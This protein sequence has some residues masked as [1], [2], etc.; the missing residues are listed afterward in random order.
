MKKKYRD[1]HTVAVGLLC[2]AVLWLTGAGR[3]EDFPK[4][5]ISNGLIRAELYLPDT[6]RGYYRATRFDWSGVIPSLRYHGH[7]YAGQWFTKYDPHIHDAIMGPVEAFAPLGYGDSSASDGRFTVIGVGLLK[8]DGSRAYSA[9]HY[10][11]IDNAG[12]WHIERKRSQVVFTQDLEQGAYPYRYSKT[13]TLVRGRPEMT[14]SHHLVN[15]GIRPIRTEVYDHNLWMLDHQPTG[16][17]CIV[18]FSFPVHAVTE[19]ARGVGSLVAVDGDSLAVLKELSG[20]EQ[21]YAV[22]NYGPDSSYDIRIENTLSGAGMHISCDRPL[23]R[24][25]FWA[26][27]TTFC[28]EAYIRINVPPGKSFDWT[29][30]YHFYSAVAPH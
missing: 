20:R 7:Q 4:A 6:A 30:T 12:R 3:P 8:Q 23:S 5:E 24:L 2:T 16:P 1:L 10:Y 18:H 19:G 15:K 29:I 27:A 28:A 21:A 13:V 9:F 17:G 22:L 26:C 25:V 11:P 14:I